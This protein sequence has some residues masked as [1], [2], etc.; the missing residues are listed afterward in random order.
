MKNKIITAAACAII[1]AILMTGCKARTTLFDPYIPTESCFDFGN[2]TADYDHYWYGTRIYYGVF[3]I[4]RD[5]TITGI[6]INVKGSDSAVVFLCDQNG[7]VLSFSS[8]SGTNVSEGW[9]TIA[10]TPVAITGGLSYELGVQ[11]Y[12]Y[13]DNNEGIRMVA[14]GS[15]YYVGNTWGNIPSSISG[16]TY[17]NSSILIYGNYCK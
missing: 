10:I 17:Y 15:M 6:S 8:P 9:N 2:Y 11:L 16:G 13:T 7:T 5:K 4:N 3:S 14:G 12:Y 1:S